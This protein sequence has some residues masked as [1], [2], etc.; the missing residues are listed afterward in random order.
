MD[1]ILLCSTGASFVGGTCGVGVAIQCG[2]CDGDNGD[3]GGNEVGS[4]DL[5]E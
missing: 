4:G 5:G 2:F 3:D 1:S